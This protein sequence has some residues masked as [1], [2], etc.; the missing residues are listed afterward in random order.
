M[1]ND[2]ETHLGLYWRERKRT[3]YACMPHLQF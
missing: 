1:N 2:D 3:I